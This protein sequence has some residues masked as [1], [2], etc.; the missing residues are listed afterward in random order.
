[1]LCYHVIY[2]SYFVKEQ[3]KN[4][5]YNTIQYNTIFFVFVAEKNFQKINYKIQDIE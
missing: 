2:V 1:M 3:I 4:I 5:Q